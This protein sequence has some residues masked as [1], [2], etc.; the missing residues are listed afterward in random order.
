M[1]YIYIL[2]IYINKMSERILYSPELKRNTDQQLIANLIDS[3]REIKT[4]VI[5]TVIDKMVSSSPR[6]FRTNINY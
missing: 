1:A 6:S 3:P 5:E 4:S 2:L